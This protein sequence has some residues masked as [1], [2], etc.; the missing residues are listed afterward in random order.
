MTFHKGQKVE[1][2]RKSDDESWGEHMDQY[3]GR[4][5]LSPTRTPPRTTRTP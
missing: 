2:F 3:V 4:P 5:V 1:I